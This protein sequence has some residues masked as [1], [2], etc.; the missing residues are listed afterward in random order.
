MAK[1]SIIMPVYNAQDSL[2]ASVSSVLAST[3]SDFELILVDD[4]SEDASGEI[5]EQLAASDRRVKAIHKVNGGPA[6]ARNAGLDAACGKWISW[7]DADDAIKPDYFEELMNAA[8]SASVDIVISDCLIDGKPFN[9]L[10]PNKIYETSEQIWEDLFASKLPW[11]LWAKLYRASLFNGLRF[12]ESDYIAEDLDM[13]ARI[14]LHGNLRMATISSTGYLYAVNSGSV[15][16][17]FDER[18]LVQFDIFE[19]VVQMAQNSDIVTDCPSCIFYAERCL[20]ATKKAYHA[21]ALNNK[22]IRAKVDNALK[23]HSKELFASKAA[24]RG[25]KLRMHLAL[26]GAFWLLD[27]V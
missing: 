19:R 10:I 18:H 13:N 11:S 6:S 2:E 25:L 15:D 22:K 9:F 1:L 21:K 3:F 26:A 16:N 12:N 14:F 23:L 20:N 7:V 4:G 17:S 5:C 8:Q 24:D 27:K